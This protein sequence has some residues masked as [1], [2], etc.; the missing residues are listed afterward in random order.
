MRR[1]VSILLLLSASTLWAANKNAG[2]SGAQFL[3]IG[4]G[5]RPTSMGE[6]FVGIADDVN[7]VYFNPAG[8]GSLDRAEITAM[9]TNYFQDMNYDFGAFAIPTSHGAFGISAVTLQV[10]DLEKRDTSEASQGSFDSLDA[11]YGL[12][13]GRKLNDALSVG[14]TARYIKQEI[15]TAR[16]SAWAGDIGILH[17]FNKAPVS[18]GLALRNMGQSVKFNDEGDPQP[19]IVDF[20]V[21]ARLFKEKL[22]LGVNAK[23]PRDNDTQF[24]LGSE[25]NQ[26]LG[27]DFKLALRA[28][29]NSTITDADG[30]G[31]SFGGGIGFRQFDFDVAWVP[32]GDL[33]NSMRYALRVRF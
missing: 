23:K 10:Q 6:A 15:D 31:V 4:A 11:A 13:Y 20:G 7:S 3:K 32:F 21:G 26:H 14:V 9:H 28:G 2:T 24:G 22:L 18:L 12:S 16:A 27:D 8:L 17:R 29:Y 33:G 1:A 19:F 30:S 25:W 5:A